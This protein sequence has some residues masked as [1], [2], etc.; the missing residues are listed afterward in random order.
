MYISSQSGRSMAEIIGVLA[1]TGVLSIGTTW[2]ITYAMDKHKANTLLND[3]K[4]VF[5]SETQQQTTNTPSDWTK[6]TSFTP[7]TTYPLYTSKNSTNN[8]F[9]LA[10]AVPK[11]VCNHLLEMETENN[12]S[13]FNK[14]GYP[15]SNCLESND[16]I[17]SFL[18]KA[19]GSSCK[20]NEDCGTSFNGYCDTQYGVCRPCENGTTINE[21]HTECI[22]ECNQSS[23]LS[24]SYQNFGWCC[25]S[26]TICNPKPNLDLLL[27]EACLPTDGL[28][29]CDFTPPTTKVEANCSCK[30]TAPTTTIEATCAYDFTIS[31]DGKTSFSLTSGYQACPSGQYCYLKY[32]DNGC[33]TSASAS[34]TGTLYG[35]CTDLT[36][37]NQGCPVQTSSTQLFSECTGCGNGQYCYLKYSNTGCTA[38]AA[39]SAGATG[40]TVLYGACTDLTLANQGCPVEISS[41]Q[42]FSNCTGCG[43][44]QYCYLKY[45]THSSGTC[46]NASANHDGK[47]YG[48]CLALPSTSAYCP[49]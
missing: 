16:I 28:C 45:K 27:E 36:L 12:L 7:N 23:E 4:L 24:C 40:E 37:V 6:V 19:L 17:F 42:P 33:G 39:A 47:L 14:F 10:Q 18:G 34:H 5:I 25:P 43:E 35:A 46:S 15:F 29:S 13:F 48:S 2:G 44:G 11:G 3:A 1:I 21:N 20:T 41:T 9:V 31:E 8:I 22:A 30:F 38:S 26:N 49:M 32:S